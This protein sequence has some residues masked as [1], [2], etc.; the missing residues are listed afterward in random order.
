V[1]EKEIPNG[2][3]DLFVERAGHG[4][5]CEI[6]VTTTIDHEVGNAQKCLRAGFLR[7]AVIC[8]DE[9]RLRKI[10]NSIATSL[11][12]DLSKRVSYY[13]PEQFIAHLKELAATLAVP[14]PASTPASKSKRVR[15]GW[16]VTTN[17]KPLSDDERIAREQATI[18]QMAALMKKV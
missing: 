2:S 16:E 3:I 17:A 18:A 14:P 4:I 7:V 13:N 6:S 15:K 8:Q 12:P 1:I 5:A 9:A 11:G 10:E